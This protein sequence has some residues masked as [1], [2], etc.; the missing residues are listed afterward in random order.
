MQRELQDTAPSNASLGRQEEPH[1][2][3]GEQ[4]LESMPWGTAAVGETKGG[5]GTAQPVGLTLDTGQ[6][7]DQA[8]SPPS[9][10]LPPPP[11]SASTCASEQRE[12]QAHTCQQTEVQT[13]R[14]KRVG[15]NPVSAA[16][17]SAT[18]GGV[19]PPCR[20]RVWW[21]GPGAPTLPRIIQQ[22]RKHAAAIGARAQTG[23][24]SL[25]GAACRRDASEG[26]LGG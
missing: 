15:V 7:G 17:S 20:S 6:S 11:G 14:E 3:R 13:E 12:R 10:Q 1:G 2:G 26:G 22:Q 16:R 5:G 18:R 25:V 19:L 4:T 21:A 24:R 9:P 23:I 8:R